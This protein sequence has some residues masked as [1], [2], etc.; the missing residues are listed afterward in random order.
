MTFHWLFFNVCCLVIGNGNALGVIELLNKK[1]TT[2]FTAENERE[3]GLV[4]KMVARIVERATQE[5]KSDIEKKGLKRIYM[6]DMEE[7]KTGRKTSTKKRRSSIPIFHFKQNMKPP[8]PKADPHQQ[9]HPAINTS[10]Q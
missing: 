1:R 10:T 6:Y 5:V 2:S 7:S 3:L 9:P 4:C 8:E